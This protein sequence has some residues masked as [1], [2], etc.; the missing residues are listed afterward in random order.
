MQWGHGRTKAPVTQ[1]GGIHM[2]Q[3]LDDII[4]SPRSIDLI[5]A[6]GTALDLPVAAFFGISTEHDEAV[7]QASELLATFNAIRDAKEREKCLTFVRSVLDSQ[8][9][10][11]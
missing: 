6:I 11:R 3:P 2:T 7:I 5:R 4:C 10:S 9:E 1:L 8:L